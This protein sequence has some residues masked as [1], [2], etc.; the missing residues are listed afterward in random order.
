L[1]GLSA[2]QQAHDRYTFS[3]QCSGESRFG[4]SKW[5]QCMLMFAIG[6][7]VKCYRTHNV[8]CSNNIKI[9]VHDTNVAVA[10]A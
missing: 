2:I 9:V 4:L 3:S 7:M 8:P 6:R 5:L 10:S 1:V